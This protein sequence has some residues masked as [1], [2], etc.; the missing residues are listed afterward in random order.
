[1]GKVCH[2]LTELS[3]HDTIMAGYYSLTF[4]FIYKSPGLSVQ[5]KKRKIDFQGD[6]IGS[7]LD[8]TIRTILAIFD[9]LVILMLPI[10]FQDNW[11]FISG[12][13]AKKKR[14]FRWQPS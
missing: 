8:F 3:A 11:P 2:C 4:L 13:E 14:V 7:H 5:E 9:L 6:R 10:K 12:E 1:M